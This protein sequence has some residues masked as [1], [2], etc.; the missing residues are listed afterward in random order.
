MQCEKCGA[1]PTGDANE[2]QGTF[3]A[4]DYKSIMAS[5]S[6]ESV[7]QDCYRA[8]GWEAVKT[9]NEIMPFDEVSL[10]FKRD[11]TI[12]GNVELS[13]LQAQCDAALRELYAIEKNQKTAGMIPA[14]SVGVVS[15][16]ILGAGMVLCMTTERV[17]AGIAV[18]SIGLIGCA[19]PLYVNKRIRAEKA[20]SFVA[21]SD[22]QYDKI[23]TMCEKAQSLLRQGRI[24]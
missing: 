15:S 7:Y 13:T 1:L 2:G 10:S 16:L 11:R 4:Y 22:A 23:I 21:A 17:V 18:G 3:T 12:K 8:F 20:Q 19:F 9:D 14:L 24:I 5:K 6:M